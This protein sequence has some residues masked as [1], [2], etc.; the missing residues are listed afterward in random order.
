MCEAGLGLG[1]LGE[2]EEDSSTLA[3]TFAE[4]ASAVGVVADG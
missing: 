1:M 4:S 3:S 2:A